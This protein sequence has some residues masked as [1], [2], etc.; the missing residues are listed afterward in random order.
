MDGQVKAILQQL[1]DDGLADRTIV[2][3]WGDHGRGLP[4]AKRFVYDSGLKVPLIVRWPGTIAPGSVV[5][6]LVSLMDLGPTDAGAGRRAGAG[7]TC[8]AERF[9]GPGSLPPA[10]MCFRTATGW[11]KRTT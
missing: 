9:W 3:F 10:S 1:E 8:R 7:R 4:R 6:D 2:F 11:T 5:A